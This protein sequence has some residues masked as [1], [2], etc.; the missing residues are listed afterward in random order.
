MLFNDVSGKLYGY[1]KIC[2]FSSGVFKI[3]RLVRYT[4]PRL[5]NLRVTYYCVCAVDKSSRP[6]PALR[7]NYQNIFPKPE[8]DYS[9]INWKICQLVSGS[10]S[11]HV[12]WSYIGKKAQHGNYPFSEGFSCVDTIQ[13]PFTS[14]AKSQNFRCRTGGLRLTDLINLPRM[15]GTLGFRTCRKAARFQYT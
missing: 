14:K 8:R 6:F 3:I 4:I 13:S 10:V 15:S 12:I 1:V 5:D 7:I 9:W 11:D 2:C